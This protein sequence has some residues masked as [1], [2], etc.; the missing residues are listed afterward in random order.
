MS[1]GAFA[2]HHEDGERGPGDSKRLE[3]MAQHLDLSDQQKSQVAQIM[4]AQAE[5]RKAMMQAHKAQRDAMQADMRSQL[6]G[7]LTA[8]QMQKLDNMREER[9]ERREEKNG[10][11]EREARKAQRALLSPC[12]TG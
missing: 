4:K 2:M 10:E 1:A 6:S 11:M 7:V 12:E 8:E 5:K 3:K 9:D